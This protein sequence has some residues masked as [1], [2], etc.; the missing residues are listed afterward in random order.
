MRFLI[1]F[2]FIFNISFATS[3]IMK[4]A[5][6]LYSDS[7]YEEAIHEY[8]RALFFENNIENKKLIKLKLAKCYREI[9]NLTLSEKA[10]KEY[11][12]MCNNEEDKYNGFLELGITYIYAKNISM[13]VYQFLKIENFSENRELKKKALFYLTL[14]YAINYQWKESEESLLRLLELLDEKEKSTNSIEN[15][16]KLYKKAKN[17]GYKSPEL[18]KWLSIIPG[19]GQIYAQDIQKKEN[20]Y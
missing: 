9:E 17:F 14:G 11:I 5:D 8:K 13:A 7:L 12:D 15:L 2:F 16:K 4:F 20:G 19:L 10:I 6:K 1:S 18:A 3:E